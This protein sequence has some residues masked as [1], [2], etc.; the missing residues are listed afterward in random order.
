MKKIVSI[1]LCM[2]VLFGCSSNKVDKDKSSNLSNSTV[3]YTLNDVTKELVGTWIPH[4]IGNWT[5]KISEDG[6]FTW[7]TN[8]SKVLELAYE[9]YLNSFD[10]YQPLIQHD[11]EFSN[12]YGV[13]IIRVKDYGDMLVGQG[14]DGSYKFYFWGQ[15][16]S[17]SE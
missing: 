2:M 12:D 15:K 7:S 8:E 4:G 11:P 1:I 6:T 10:E 17:K 5:I 13:H 3:T 9:A 16:W 14:D